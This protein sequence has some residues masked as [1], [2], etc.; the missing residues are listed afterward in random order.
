[1]LRDVSRWLGSILLLAAAT[2]S[3]RGP[4]LGFDGTLVILLVYRLLTT[5]SFF[6]ALFTAIFVAAVTG[7]VQ[8]EWALADR[9]DNLQ[10]PALAIHV[11]IF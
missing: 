9:T 11:L 10:Q 6:L 3:L 7:Q 5:P 1:L 8:V 4:I 2:L